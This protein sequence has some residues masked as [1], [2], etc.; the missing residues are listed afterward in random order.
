MKSEKILSVI[1]PVYNE[2]KTVESILDKVLSRPETGE[3]IIV[4]DASSDKS[5]EVIE[6]YIDSNKDK[7]VKLFNQPKNKGNNWHDKCPILGKRRRE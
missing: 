6:K 5:V 4:N 1:I 7:N 3:I 2:E